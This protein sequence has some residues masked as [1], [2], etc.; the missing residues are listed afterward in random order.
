[1]VEW[2]YA[3]RGLT[4]TPWH[5]GR[6][7][8]QRHRYSWSVGNSAAGPHPVGML[9]PNRFGL[10]DSSGNV[11]EWCQDRFELDGR[12]GISREFR[13]GSYRDSLDQLR[14]A[15]RYGAIPWEIYG[16]I[17]LRIAR[18]VSSGTDP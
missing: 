18:T 5:W 12:G 13:G 3:A 14:P 6:H 16:H 10:F 1:M 2:E 9:K 7:E 4:E 15:R 17:G 8:T 11:A